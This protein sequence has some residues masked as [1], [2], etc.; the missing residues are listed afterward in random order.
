MPRLLAFL[1]KDHS[2][3]TQTSAGDFIKAIVTISANASQ[4]EQ[5]CIGPNNLTR[6]LV[7]EPCIEN[8]LS[9]MLRGGYPLTVGVGMIIEVI[10]KNNSDYDPDVGQ[11][12]ESTPSNSDPIYLGTLLRCFARRVPD[13]MSLLLNPDHAGD[14][15]NNRATTKRQELGVAFGNKIEPL[16]FDRF[17]TC[18]L[19][20]ELLHCSNMGL[21]NERGSEAYIKERDQERERLR[22]EGALTVVRQPA[23]AVTEFSEDGTSLANGTSP[24]VAIE[25]PEGKRKLEVANSSIEDDG[26]EDVGN[27][28]DLGDD[29]KDDFDEK[30]SF[31]IEPEQAK[32]PGLTKSVRPR[33]D[34]DEDFVDEPLSSP[35]LE[36]ADDKET[37]GESLQPDS[38]DSE[39]QAESPTSGLASGV[40]SLAVN[41]DTPM[42]NHDSPPIGVTKSPEPMTEAES[43]FYNVGAP[44]LPHRER[45]GQEDSAAPS[46]PGGL[47]PHPDD[48][49]SP[50]F[51]SRPDHPA[52][53]KETPASTRN[54]TPSEHTID[55]TQVEGDT[56]RSLFMSG[57]DQSFAPHFEYDVDGQ[58][59]VGDFLKMMFVEHQV[60]PTILVSRVQLNF[61]VAIDQ[62][63]GLF[64]S[65]PVEQ[66]PSQRRV[67]CCTAGFQRTNG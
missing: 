44:P 43:D 23:S 40:D 7:S 19:M 22:A 12:P 36:A 20:A 57:N 52:S 33:L 31:E 6:Q 28:V 62:S 18:E 10:R 48:K 41:A 35:R 45:Q 50:L 37:E 53:V 14:E 59:I 63:P 42:E 26:F 17:K 38:T 24:I 30:T 15:G 66:F 60:V 49:P 2:P 56:S 51:A 13:F 4:N 55:T 39:P 34:L 29:L 1:N 67:R 21:L 54:D 27:P 8:L 47:S 9:N 16:G 11:G 58:P 61:L 3:G 65:I 64:F 25:E 32:I 46:S 5:S